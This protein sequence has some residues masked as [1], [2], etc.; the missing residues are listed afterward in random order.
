MENKFYKTI[1][2]GVELYDSINSLDNPMLILPK[3]SEMEVLRIN[4]GE[5]YEFCEV[6]YGDQIYIIRSCFLRGI[7]A[8]FSVQYEDGNSS[9]YG[10]ADIKIDDVKVGKPFKSNGKY[11]IVLE[12][13]YF[14]SAEL[15][16]NLNLTDTN[17]LKFDAASKLLKYY[18]KDMDLPDID[19]KILEF[20]MNPFGL[21]EVGEYEYS[22]RPNKSIKVK[23]SIEEK[24]F[25]IFEDM[26]LEKYKILNIHKDFLSTNFRANELEENIKKLSKIMDKYHKMSS[27]FRGNLQGL[28]FNKLSKNLRKFYSDFKIFLAENEVYLNSALDNKIEIGF[29]KETGAIEYV[30]FFDPYGRFLKIGMTYL[31]ELADINVSKTIMNYKKILHCG[32]V[33]MSWMDF[34]KNNYSGEFVIDIKSKKDINTIT[35][36]P[37]SSIEKDIQAISEPHD[38]YSVRTYKEQSALLSDKRDPVY[39]QKATEMLVRTRDRIG[40]RFLLELPDIILNINDIESLYE[41]VLNKISIKDLVDILMERAGYDLDISELDEIKIR[42]VLKTFGTNEVLDIL[43]SFLDLESFVDF[44]L[45]VCDIY[46][47]GKKEIDDFLGSINVIPQEIIGFYFMHFKEDGSLGG[48][49]PE[50]YQGDINS[51]LQELGIYNCAKLAILI[52][53]GHFK[54]S[55]FF[56]ERMFGEIMCEILKNGFPSYELNNPCQ[57][58]SSLPSFDLS[59][60]KIDIFDFFGKLNPSFM[61]EIVDKYVGD[62]FE[63]ARIAQQNTILA[64][65]NGLNTS[66]PDQETPVQLTRKFFSISKIDCGVQ[67]LKASKKKLLKN[68]EGINITF[69]KKKIDFPIEFPSPEETNPSFDFSDFEFK[70]L[71]DIFA[72]SIDSIE[73]SIR[74]GIEEALIVSFK[75]LLNRLLEAMNSDM[76]GLDMQ[77]YGTININDILDASKDLNSDIAAEIIVPKI[78]IAVAKRRKS[79][80]DNLPRIEYSPR[81]EDIKKMFDDISKSATPFEV[82]RVLKGDGNGKDFENLTEG[83]DENI[84]SVLTEDLFLEI[85]EELSDVADYDLLEDLEVAYQDGEKFVNVC[86]SYGIPLDFSK[87]KDKFREKLDELDKEITPEIED[88]LDNIVNN[89]KK[90]KKKGFIDAI[91]SVKENH[92]DFLLF[93]ESPCSYMPAQSSIPALNFV[94]NM[95]FD[96]IFDSIKMQ[97]KNETSNFQDAFLSTTSSEGYVK[98]KFDGTEQFISEVLTNSLGEL[99]YQMQ[100]LSS[101]YPGNFPNK[102]VFNKEFGY[103]F[104]GEGDE[105]FIYVSGNY[106]KILSDTTVKY[107][108]GEWELDKNPDNL[109]EVEIYAKKRIPTLVPLPETKKKVDNKKVAIHGSNSRSMDK[110]S[111]LFRSNSI[112]SKYDY[113]KSMVSVNQY[114]Q[115]SGEFECLD[116]V[117]YADPTYTSVGFRKRVKNHLFALSDRINSFSDER[118]QYSRTIIESSA[119]SEDSIYSDSEANN[120]DMLSR[121]VYDFSKLVLETL[122]THRDGGGS[123]LFNIEDMITFIIDDGNG[124]DLLRLDDAKNTAKQ[125]FNS[126]CSFAAGDDSLEKSSVKQLAY[127]LIRIQIIEELM[128]NCFYNSNAYDTIA[129]DPFIFSVFKGL[130]RYLI[131]VPDVFYEQ[132]KE[133]YLELYGEEFNNGSGAFSRLV[134]EIYS[135]LYSDF[136]FFFNRGDEFTKLLIKYGFSWD[137]G[138]DS[139]FDFTSKVMTS[140]Q[141]GKKFLIHRVFKNIVNGDEITF[142]EYR[143]LD[144]PRRSKYK[145]LLRLSYICT[146]EDKFFKSEDYTNLLSTGLNFKENILEG[147][148]MKRLTNVLAYEYQK[149]PYFVAVDGQPPPF[150]GVVDGYDFMSFYLLPLGETNITSKVK[151]ES[152]IFTLQSKESLTDM[153]LEGSMDD[154]E[155]IN[156]IKDILKVDNLKM[157]AIELFKTLE[158]QEKEEID[159]MFSGTKMMMIK[160]IQILSEDPRIFFNKDYLSDLELMNQSSEA[161][162][163]PDFSDIAR[164]MA[165]MTVP[166]IIKG[167]AEQFDPNIKIASKIRKG[168]SLS[169]VNIPPQL[170]SLMALPMN[171]IPFAPGPPIGPLGLLYL[172]TGFL[173]PKER[174]KLAEIGRQSLEILESQENPSQGGINPTNQGRQNGSDTGRRN[175]FD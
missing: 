45:T 47:F 93:D 166:M 49:I 137:L 100:D 62:R 63:N 110:M 72:D 139:L 143:M 122:R 73:T 17:N 141:R 104:T 114:D 1:I 95:I 147:S 84:K 30:L 13:G 39:R 125:E 74:N 88:E 71:D 87:I 106:E 175:P 43:F 167:F 99:E 24:Y 96:N 85:F 162:T 8:E 129:T 163:T 3:D 168:A 15:D 69:E 146:E 35:K 115:N 34:A 158:V 164:R 80:C 32:S 169:G 36:K 37:I 53:N 4:L 22:T 111:V 83:I 2:D 11:H 154:F 52:K 133:I 61:R 10:G 131:S 124:L 89:L 44:N 81:K 19:V 120:K 157:T 155:I 54:P 20:C 64:G 60:L 25:K 151:D 42:G 108:D 75:S 148:S 156:V 21:I 28:N 97:Y 76:G 117:Q 118:K 170:A 66:V 46:N 171:L 136:K 94:N 6:K 26:S 33:N 56:Q 101:I 145:V 173:D 55:D 23:F 38:E 57:E 116:D 78:E 109:L 12:T 90:K 82:I 119:K 107:K 126:N 149:N 134:R 92:V 65:D 98:L 31:C 9:V 159:L 172:A 58:V 18:G 50:R 130:E 102:G 123:N 48:M 41:L 5:L 160:N 14:V 128:K 103:N 150:P 67:K 16:A 7:E 27:K 70:S 152:S 86:D 132:W 51:K 77:E 105:L 140:Y 29:N 91:G 121:M 161:S 79:I 138:K 174:K 68:K 165:L 113:E 144:Q 135:E 112:V 59:L 153:I 127:L 142:S 40:D